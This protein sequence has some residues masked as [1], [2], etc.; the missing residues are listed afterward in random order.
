ME[1]RTAVTTTTTT[2][3]T[4]PTI[5]TETWAEILWCAYACRVVLKTKPEHILQA[6]I[7]FR[8]TD[9]PAS[10]GGQRE[11]EREWA[12]YLCKCTPTSVYR[13][14]IFPP[15]AQSFVLYSRCCL[16]SPNSPTARLSSNDLS[17]PSF[18][19][20][21]TTKIDQLHVATKGWTMSRSEI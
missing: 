12:E 14:F 7:G 19:I 21:I 20:L 10:S 6:W 8:G 18:I 1:N 5:V 11:A 3:T 13:P 16:P 9:R 17:F 2:T 4:R 15:T